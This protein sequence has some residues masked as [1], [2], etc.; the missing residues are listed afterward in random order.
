MVEKHCDFE[1]VIKDTNYKDIL[2][3]FVQNKKMGIPTYKNT[4][5]SGPDHSKCFTIQVLINNQVIAEGTAKNK[6]A[7]EQ[8]AAM[9][10]LKALELVE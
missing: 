8:N 10:A 7:A 3:K 9:R 5:E 1:E 4:H 2:M 6:K